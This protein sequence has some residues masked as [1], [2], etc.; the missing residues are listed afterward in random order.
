MKSGHDA[1]F[2]NRLCVLIFL[3]H[4]TRSSCLSDEHP[5]NRPDADMPMRTHYSSI[6]IRRTRYND[7]IVY[8]AFEI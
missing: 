6:E 5:R 3:E 7:C 1:E 2:W 4:S 8:S